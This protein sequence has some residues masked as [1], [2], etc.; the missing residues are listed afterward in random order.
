MKEEKLKMRLVLIF[1]FL[2]YQNCYS[3]V[4]PKLTNDTTA[5]SLSQ[6]VVETQT[7]NQLTDNLKNITTKSNGNIEEKLDFKQLGFPKPTKK[8]S[9]KF[10]EKEHPSV[11]VSELIKNEDNDTNKKQKENLIEEK[12]IKIKESLTK[13]KERLEE[14]IKLIRDLNETKTSKFNTETIPVTQSPNIPNTENNQNIEEFRNVLNFFNKKF[15]KNQEPVNEDIAKYIY[16]ILAQFSEQMQNIFNN[17]NLKDFLEFYIS[18]NDTATPNLNV[19]FNFN[20]G[21]KI[22]PD[23]KEQQV[24]IKIRL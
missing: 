15:L 11:T 8:L 12:L 9:E 2:F 19:K 5:T 4:V 13:R 3:F 1:T 14:K 22:V 17:K 24:G 23:I 20:F 10:L 7:E 6:E 21:V 18:K 16:L